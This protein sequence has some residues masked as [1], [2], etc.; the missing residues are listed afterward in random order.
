MTQKLEM[1]K[2]VLQK[3]LSNTEDGDFLEAIED[4]IYSCQYETAT[5]LEQWIRSW[6]VLDQPAPKFDVRYQQGVQFVADEWD[7]I[8]SEGNL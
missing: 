3:V 5:P 2:G 1:L 4:G 8:L 7:K 6:E